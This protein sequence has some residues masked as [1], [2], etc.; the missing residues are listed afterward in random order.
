LNGRIVLDD[1][2]EIEDI[3][4]SARVDVERNGQTLLRV[5]VEHAR[6]VSRKRLAG[7]LL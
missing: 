5:A 1:A 2:R 6:R 7:E 4:S 3:A